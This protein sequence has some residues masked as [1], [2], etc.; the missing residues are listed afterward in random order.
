MKKNYN[1]GY[2]E[3]IRIP[4]RMYPFQPVLVQPIPSTWT[5]EDTGEYVLV[6][7]DQ[8]TIELHHQVEVLDEN[9]DPLRDIW[10]VYGFP[11]GGPDLSWLTP[12]ETYWPGA[13]AVLRGNAQKTTLAGYTQHTFKDGGE[14]IWIWDVDENGILKLPSTI[15]KN[16]K[17]TSPPIGWS[18][19]TGVRLRFQRRR[20][21]IL[22]REDRTAQMEEMIT[23]LER[24]MSHLAK[25]MGIDLSTIAPRPE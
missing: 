5:G 25:E 13:P 18:N 23:W 8:S 21:D 14:D 9:G 11:G 7:I 16:C 6:D 1:Y 4:E 12:K 3:I 10:V 20:K 2:E 22:P 24:G 19:H 15:V 17:W